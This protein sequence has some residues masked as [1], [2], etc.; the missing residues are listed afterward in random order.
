MM[1][2]APLDGATTGGGPAPSACL[3]RL[4]AACVT[5]CTGQR[6]APA[7]SAWLA[8][9]PSLNACGPTF[10][11][12]TRAGWRQ[13]KAEF[14]SGSGCQVCRLPSDGRGG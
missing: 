6:G 2:V 12:K 7:L 9:Q 13:F 5:G 1:A 8:K 10:V 3:A 11:T 14:G 4:L